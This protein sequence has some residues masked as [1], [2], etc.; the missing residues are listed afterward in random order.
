MPLTE[1]GKKIRAN[2]RREYGDK[3][4]SYFYA[5]RN[6]GRIS[7]VDRGKRKNKRRSRR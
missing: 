7:G 4:D 2:F 3:G 6:S 5:S 1:K